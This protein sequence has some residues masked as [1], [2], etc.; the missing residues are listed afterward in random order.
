MQI[1]KNCT[2]YW[3]YLDIAGG[4]QPVAS[5][6]F[7]HVLLEYLV[8]K[9]GNTKCV[10]WDLAHCGFL[11]IFS[12]AMYDIFMAPPVRGEH[13]AICISPWRFPPKPERFF[14]LI[15]ILAACGITMLIIDW[16][17]LFPWTVDAR[18]ATADSFPDE[19][20]AALHRRAKSR[21]VAFVPCIPLGSDMGC[22]LSMPTYRYLAT[23]LRDE[24]IL[25]LDA[26]GSQKFACELADDILELLPEIEYIFLDLP[27]HNG[28]NEEPVRM[29]LREIEDRN[30]RWIVPG[31]PRSAGI[32]LDIRRDSRTL[33]QSAGT[34]WRL[35]D[36]EGWSEWYPPSVELYIDVLNRLQGGVSQN[37]IIE[38]QRLRHLIETFE[39]TLSCCWNVVR[40]L[41]ELLATVCGN[42]S[43]SLRELHAAWIALSEFTNLLKTLRK[44]SRSIALHFDGI[45]IS[46]NTKAWLAS[47]IEP[48]HEERSVLS[49]RLRQFGNRGELA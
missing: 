45:V 26:P 22:F 35:N 47:R 11:V 21:G 39:T 5:A 43:Q 7:H 18:F 42:P 36:I 9:A 6:R 44:D 10:A 32:S 23:F 41:R 19:A 30:L 37:A 16:G 8:N 2:F 25:N 46:S 15:D 14:S 3:T 20:I 24:I 40:R 29:L 17:P 33:S 31:A 13:N 34:M 27:V 48:L 49:S 12:I 4:A 1:F 38:S 28:Q